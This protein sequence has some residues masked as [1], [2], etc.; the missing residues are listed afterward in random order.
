MKY[1]FSLTRI[2]LLVPWCQQKAEIADVG[3]PSA[4]P[5]HS[6]ICT[7]WYSYLRQNTSYLTGRSFNVSCQ[8]QTSIS[9]RLSTGVH[10]GSVLRPLLFAVYTTSL[11]SIIHSH[12]FSY[13]CYAD[14]TQLYLSF[15]PDDLMVL[16]HIHMDEGTPP[17]TKPLYKSINQSIY[18]N[19]N[20]K[21][22][23]SSLTQTKVVRNLGVMTDYQLSFADHVASVSWLSCFVLYNIRKNQG[24]PD[25]VCHPTLGRGHGYFSPQ[26]FKSPSSWSPSMRSKTLIDG[27]ERI[28]ASGFWSP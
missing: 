10:Q 4:E 23:S 12:D 1:A 11:G 24:I 9:H 17:S 8:G 7:L 19:I 22:A 27:P 14:N 28:S 20:L 16:R 18:H 21:I 5:L 2:L 26:L 13:H 15:L 25:S 3:E 6:A